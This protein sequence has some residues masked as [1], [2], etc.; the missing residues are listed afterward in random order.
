MSSK[1]A[2]SLLAICSA[3]LL[4]GCSMGSMFASTG[5]SADAQFQNQ[6]ASQEEMMAGAPSALPAIATECPPIR[7]RNGGEALFYYGS[8]QVGNARDLHY[9]AVMEE[10]SRNCVV[11]RNVITINM[12][13]TGRV[14][15][16]PD[17]NE[18]SVDLPIRFAVES[19][20]VAVFSE[21][22]TKNVAIAPGQQSAGF[23][24]VIQNVAIPY[25]G[26][27]SITIWVG[28]DPS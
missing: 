23:E 9:Q 13:V 21:K 12:G 17:G 8:G 25:L 22:Y 18:Q 2:A 20:G 15:L 26:G 24:Q 14:L 1:F 27:E 11:S 10:Q 19:N 28:F 4:S 3:A 5:P 6:T 7:V 16:G